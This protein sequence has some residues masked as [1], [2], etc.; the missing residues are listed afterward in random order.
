M[1]TIQDKTAEFEK[2]TVEYDGKN[3][4]REGV[5]DLVSTYRNRH[6]N[7][8]SDLKSLKNEHDKLAGEMNEELAKQRTMMD[9]IRTMTSGKKGSVSRGFRGILGKIPLVGRP[10]R[11]KPLGD[12][13]EERVESADKRTREVDTYLKKVEEAM[14]SLRQDQEILR[15]KLLDAAKNRKLTF[16][17]I[18]DLQ[19][20]LAEI[21][22][23]TETIDD[24]NSEEFR[25]L[26][27]EIGKLENLIWENGQRLRLFNNAQDRL[28]SIIRM[29][30]NFLEISVNLHGNMTIIRET[31]EMVLD[32]LRQHV[33]AIATLA[34]AGELTLELTQSMETLKDNMSK[35]AQIASETSLFLTKNVESI[36]DNMRVYDQQTEDVVENN[37]A[38]ERQLR[39]Q[40]LEQIIE[41]VKMEKSKSETEEAI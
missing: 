28:Q 11:E 21:K 41:K 12:L 29:N 36:T 6:E 15:E 22:A 14:K 40:Q 23:E 26:D 30:S 18:E 27:L 7:H 4:T 25:A 39:K 19:N 35:V 16:T 20:H 38:Q 2:K 24:K 3:Y 1:S 31:A 32:E 17:L 8:V 34:E 5:K 10:F 33:T 9:E 13:L 37:L